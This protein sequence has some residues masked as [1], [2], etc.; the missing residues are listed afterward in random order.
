LA[1]TFADQLLVF[2]ANP[3]NQNTLP[4]TVGMPAFASASFKRRYSK[5]GFQVNGTTFGALSDFRVQRGFFAETRMTGFREKR[6]ELPERKWYDLRIGRSGM[7][8]ADAT[9]TMPVQ[10][11]IEAVPGSIQMG[12]GGDLVAAG[13]SEPAPLKH[14]L[15]FQLP[16]MTGAFTLDYELNTL[17]FAAS[18][19]SPVAD[20]RRIQRLRR[21]LEDDPQFL[22]S[23]DGAPGQTPYIFVLLYQSGALQGTGLSETAAVQAFAAADVLAAFITIPPT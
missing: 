15:K 1:V 12:P 5:E 2:L 17:V 7:A 3:A 8:W 21:L 9:F 11:A 22:V 4:S 6:S 10:F 19:P 18:D 14:L 13:V 20:L 23:L 16:V